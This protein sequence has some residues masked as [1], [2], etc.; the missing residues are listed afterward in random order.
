MANTKINTTELDFDSIKNNLKEF[1]KGQDTFQDYDFDGSGLSVLLDVLAYNTHYN[2]LYSNLAIN[3]MFLDSARKRNSVVSLSKM[4]GY[5]PKSANCSKAQL[6]VKVSSALA[7][8]ETLIL[9]AN[10]QFST[11][12]NGVTYN[13]YTRS[14]YTTTGTTL[15]TFSNVEIVEGVPLTYKFNV[16]T[17]AKYVIP[18]INVDIDTLTVR[19]QEN[20]TSSVIETFYRAD[21]ILDVTATSNVYWIKEID[22]QLYEIVFGNDVIGKALSNGN[23]I[24]LSYMVSNLDLP[25]GAKLFNAGAVTFVSGN[26]VT[27]TNGIVSLTT[28]S[29]AAGG[30]DV[31][32]I[33]SIRFSAP[34]SYSAQNRSVT[35]DDYKALIYESVPEAESVSVWGGE[36][37]TP[38]VYG[39]VYVCI[40]PFDADFLT[41]Q[42]KNDILNGILKPKTVL[43]LSPVIVDPEYINIVVNATVYYNELK[44]TRTGPAIESLV[45]DAIIYYNDTELQ[46]FDG[47]MKYSKLSKIIDNSESSIVSNITTITFKRKLIP[48]YNVQAQYYINL[49][50][51]IYYS[52]V[53]EDIVLSSGFYIYGSTEIHYVVDDGMGTMMLFYVSDNNRIV[54]DSSIGTV[55]YTNGIINI[56]D[57]HITSIYGSTLELNIKPSSNDVSSAFTQIAQIMPSMLTVSAIS[58][59]SANG[60][61]RGGKNYV[62]TT[63]RI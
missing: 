41:T 18:N 11:S 35:S 23:I 5:T 54:V 56:T 45:R 20:I 16:S 37:A 31:E 17:G 1:L 26:N 60:D 25:N 58:D 22:D 44:T 27:F 28:T 63:S 61:L 24:N 33:E 39:K 29:S 3:E 52:G 50:N 48:K 2:A 6:T 57:L 51:P 15:Y 43:T 46:R 53:P 12:V 14:D 19:V 30:K 40:K 9:P 42:Q 59:K 21:S 32:D 4:L 47:V 8:P 7:G 13:F 10:S 62:F 55:D 36:D 38:P 49:V 34:K